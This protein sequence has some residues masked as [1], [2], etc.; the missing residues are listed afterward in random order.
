LNV[1]GEEAGNLR[2]D[3]A[4]EFAEGTTITVDAKDGELTFKQPKAKVPAAA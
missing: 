3:D 4:G 2:V 1:L